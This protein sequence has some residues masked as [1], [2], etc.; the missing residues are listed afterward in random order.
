MATNSKYKVED[1]VRRVGRPGCDGTIKEIRMELENS[2]LSEE[3]REKALMIG[4]KWDNGT[5][6]FFAPEAL[7]EA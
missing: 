7:Q 3:A 4:V 1:R 5:Y 6:S 2:G